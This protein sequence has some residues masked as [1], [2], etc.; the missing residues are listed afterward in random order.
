ME[1]RAQQQ[2]QW[3][4]SRFSGGLSPEELRTFLGGDW[5]A[6]VAVL[7]DDGWPYVIPLWYQWDGEAFYLVGRKKSVWVDDMK[8]DPRCS[9]CIDETAMPPAGGLRKVLAQCTAEVVEGPVAAEGSKWLV[10]ANEMAFR[11]AGEAGVEGLK[12]SY[13]WPRFL[14]KL[15]PRDGKLTTWQGV[16]WAARY[17]DDGRSE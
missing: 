8:R 2:E 6:K 13:S 4:D 15:A 10:I 1:T 12:A 11:Y 9:I 16:D 17:K 14:V 3:Y 7:K 5:I